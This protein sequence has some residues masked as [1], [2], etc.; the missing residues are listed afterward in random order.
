[1]GTWALLESICM[2]PWSYSHAP[3]R[4]VFAALAATRSSPTC[5]SGCPSSRP[6]DGAGQCLR[7]MMIE[8]I[9]SYRGTGQHVL[10]LVQ[11]P[12]SHRP[13]NIPASLF[14]FFSLY[15]PAFNSDGYCLTCPQA[16]CYAPSQELPALRR[17]ALK[18]LHCRVIIII[19]GVVF[20]CGW[21]CV[22]RAGGT[23]R[24]G[25]DRQPGE[26]TPFS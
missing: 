3:V 8:H 10:G 20:V 25:H 23:P 18:L 5:G 2:L 7:I 14:P 15:K 21:G 22:V 13:V 11:A 12:L 1:M 6:S 24:M 9:G 26:P 19:L 4:C 16:P 17:V